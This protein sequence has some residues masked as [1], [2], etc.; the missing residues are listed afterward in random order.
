MLLKLV[1]SRRGEKVIGGGGGGGGG[2]GDAV[3]PGGQV[4]GA[5]V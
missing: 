1:L 4:K 5:H 3:C 2:G